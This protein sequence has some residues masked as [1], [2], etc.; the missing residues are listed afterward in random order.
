MLAML[1]KG[2]GMR[3]A[4]VLP[5][6]QSLVHHGHELHV[7]D[8]AVAVNIGLLHDRI[9]LGPVQRTNLVT[10]LQCNVG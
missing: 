6:K 9:D 4:Q 7:R 1:S 10:T 3:K 8:L 2:D 5:S